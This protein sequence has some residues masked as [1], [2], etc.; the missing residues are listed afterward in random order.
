MWTYK[1]PS[2]DLSVLEAASCDQWLGS[3]KWRDSCHEV[4]TYSWSEKMDSIGLSKRR[5]SLKA[6]GRLGSNFPVSMALTD[7]RETS[8][9]WAR[10]AWDQ[11]RSARRMRSRFFIVRS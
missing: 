9:F 8:S 5:A 1:T 10:S 2:I 4:T 3:L 7:W 11:L 6:S